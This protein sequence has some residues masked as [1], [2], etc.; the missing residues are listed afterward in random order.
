MP[1]LFSYGSLQ[2]RNV[3]LTTF[4]RLVD[5]ERDALVGFETALV[6]IK[7]P[8]LVTTSGQTDHV[9]VEFNGR[10]DSRVSGVVF[11]INDAELVLAD[12]YEQLAGYKR[13]VV[14]LG[15]GKEAWVY[16]ST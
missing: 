7:D 10:A 15:S 9:N 3:Q 14:T 16:L 8:R 2:Q 1:L 13:V 5:G 12:Q 4:G 11:E 6:S